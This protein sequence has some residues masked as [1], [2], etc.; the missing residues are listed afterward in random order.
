[1]LRAA[2]LAAKLD[3]HIDAA[4]MARGLKSD[5]SST[6]TRVSV[7]VQA[8][9]DGPTPQ[10]KAEGIATAGGR[11]MGA[12]AGSSQLHCARSCGPCIVLLAGKD[13]VRFGER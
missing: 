1:M 4:A 5:L 2:R 6:S 11:G 13:A 3:M 7:K 10:E 8:I 12:A 9:V